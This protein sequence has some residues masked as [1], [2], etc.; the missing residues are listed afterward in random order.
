M[1][2]SVKVFLPVS[3]P[4]LQPFGFPDGGSHDHA[5]LKCISMCLKG[6]KEGAKVKFS[7]V[8]QFLLYDYLI[9]HVVKGDGVSRLDHRTLH[10]V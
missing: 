4:T 7:A 6:Y 8:R 10:N 1:P 5:D 3:A 2:G 9:Y